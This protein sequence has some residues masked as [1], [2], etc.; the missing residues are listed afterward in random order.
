MCQYA[1]V[2]FDNGL[3]HYLLQVFFTTLECLDFAGH[4]LP[5]NVDVFF[6]FRYKML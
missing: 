1:I 6:L 2:F 3:S 5:I 4:I